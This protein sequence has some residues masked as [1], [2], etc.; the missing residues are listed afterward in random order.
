MHHHH[1][2]VSSVGVGDSNNDLV[3]H[4]VKRYDVKS[5]V[6]SLRQH[7]YYSNCT[8]VWNCAS[9][10]KTVH[11]SWK[12]FFQW[13]CDNWRSQQEYFQVALVVSQCFFCKILRE[14]VGVGEL[15]NNVLFIVFYHLSVH[16]HDLIH[17]SFHILPWN[18]NDFFWDHLR[19]VSTVDVGSTNMTQHVQVLALLGQLQHSL[20]PKVVDLQ[21]IL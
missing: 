1:F 2:A 20:A 7:T 21:S 3:G 4:N 11:P 19:V 15:T 12:R 6:V 18:I 10:R 8:H 13:T 5:V 14:S 16:L 17:E 9:C